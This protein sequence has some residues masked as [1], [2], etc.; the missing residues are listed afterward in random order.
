MNE[1]HDRLYTQCKSL[2]ERLDAKRLCASDIGTLDAMLKEYA[3]D[4]VY[5]ATEDFHAQKIAVLNR[6]IRYYDLLIISQ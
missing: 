6:I 2:Y 3:F 4:S 5:V 1:K